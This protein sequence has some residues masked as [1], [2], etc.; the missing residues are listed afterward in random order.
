MFGI[1]P[2]GKLSTRLL[3]KYFDFSLRHRCTGAAGKLLNTSDRRHDAYPSH[4]RRRGIFCDR[5][6]LILRSVFRVAYFASE[7][8]LFSID[9]GDAYLTTKGSL[10]HDRGEHISRSLFRVAYLTTEGSLSCDRREHISI[11][12][13]FLRSIP[14]FCDL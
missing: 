14:Y 10:F 9:E 3:A 1:L 5:R 11:I 2:V 7:G 6:E 4:R 13:F 8:S 12:L